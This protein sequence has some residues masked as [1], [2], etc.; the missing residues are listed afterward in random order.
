MH[1]RHA[2]TPPAEGVRNTQITAGQVKEQAK[3][4]ADRWRPCREPLTHPDMPAPRPVGVGNL[5]T[6]PYDR[7]ASPGE[8]QENAAR[9]KVDEEQ[10]LFNIAA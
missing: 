8:R 3:G 10:K 5:Q 2:G 1:Q 4:E 6:E 9:T 7:Q